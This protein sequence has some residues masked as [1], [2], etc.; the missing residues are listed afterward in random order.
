MEVA[1]HIARKI[2]PDLKCLYTNFS[3]ASRFAHFF[4]CSSSKIKGVVLTKNMAVLAKLIAALIYT[5]SGPNVL[6]NIS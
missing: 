6:M 1:H 3:S 5:Y 4:F 2:W